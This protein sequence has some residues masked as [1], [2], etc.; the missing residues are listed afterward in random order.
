VGVIETETTALPDEEGESKEYLQKKEK[1]KT[2]IH[3]KNDFQRCFPQENAMAS[4]R[5]R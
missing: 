1:R 5:G 2:M 3:E 4:K